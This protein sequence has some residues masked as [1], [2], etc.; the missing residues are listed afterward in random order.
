MRAGDEIR[1]AKQV[2]ELLVRQPLARLD[3]LIVHHA[4][5]GRRATKGGEVQ[6]QEQSCQFNQPVLHR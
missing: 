3:R 6:P 5:V 4:D 1:D 2:K